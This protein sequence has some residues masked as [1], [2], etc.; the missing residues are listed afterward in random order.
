MSDPLGAAIEAAVTRAV[1]AQ[2]PT[3]IAALKQAQPQAPQ[4]PPP[5]EDRF[6]RMVEVARLLG[7][8]R[9]T[10]WKW[11]KSGKLPPRRHIGTASGYLLSDIKR[12]QL[13]EAA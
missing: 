8:N 9:S 1:A 13:G 6:C 3:L 7:V 11:E 5:G 10:C 4:P 12:I 2:L